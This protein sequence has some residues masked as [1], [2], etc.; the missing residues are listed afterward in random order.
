MC[1]SNKLHCCPFSLIRT[2]LSYRTLHW[3][4]V[5]LLWTS[6]DLTKPLTIRGWSILIKDF[7][8]DFE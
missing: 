5:D 2:Q 1:T 4:L 3:T 8:P 7:E 6:V